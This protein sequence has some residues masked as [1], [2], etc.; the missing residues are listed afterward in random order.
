[1][2]NGS[3]DQNSAEEAM[4][5]HEEQRK[6]PKENRCPHTPGFEFTL[7]IYCCV[8]TFSVLLISMMNGCN[9]CTNSYTTD[10]VVHVP[11]LVSS[12]FS[13]H[14]SVTCKTTSLT[15]NI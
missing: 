15:K 7:P 4:D 13:Y 12:F 6:T 1:M 3:I 9:F 2:R 5:L 10:H 8:C 11:F 14:L